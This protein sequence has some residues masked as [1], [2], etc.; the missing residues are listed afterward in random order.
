MRSNWRCCRKWLAFCLV[1]GYYHSLRRARFFC[2]FSGGSCFSASLLFGFSAFLA[3]L[4]AASLLFCLF[5]CFC[6]FL[7]SASLRF[8]LFTCPASLLFCFSASV[9]FY[10]YYSTVL[11]LFFSHVFLLLYF[12]LLCFSAACLYCL[13]EF[14]FLL[15]CI[16]SEI[17]ERP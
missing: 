7:F 2:F 17:L 16:L 11:V 4:F 13:F 5:A 14:H 10:F 1:F 12:L 15:L 8:P 3:S 6:A 9:P